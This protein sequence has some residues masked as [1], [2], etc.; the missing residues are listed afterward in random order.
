MSERVTELRGV[1][2]KNRS[3]QRKKESTYLTKS[4]VHILRWFVHIGKVNSTMLSEK[5]SMKFLK[6]YPI[7]PRKKSIV[8][9]IDYHFHVGGV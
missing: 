8:R 5:R 4:I 9:L 2:L 1:Q 6:R 7:L 3:F